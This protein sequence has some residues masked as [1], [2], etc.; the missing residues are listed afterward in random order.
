[1]EF[2]SDLAQGQMGER[3]VCDY[4]LEKR[5]EYGIVEFRDDKLYDFKLSA[6]TK[7]DL[8]FEIKTDR[9]EYFN[10]YK[11]YNMFIELKCS[12]KDSGIITT[13][14]DYF[15]YYYP[16]FELAYIIECDKL[17]KFIE[18]TELP[19][20][21]QAGDYG[22]VQGV[23]IHRMKYKNIFKRLKIKKNEELWKN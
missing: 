10:D 14:A 15:V 11:T 3:I 13:K 4:I 20:I 21:S 8:T 17:R 12:G 6:E 16:D 1:M 5:P 9:W 2:Y 22:K 19:M 7:D 23:L 18:D